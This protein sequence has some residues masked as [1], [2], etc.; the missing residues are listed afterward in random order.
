ME[1]QPGAELIYNR[2]QKHFI[3][4]S[5]DSYI[6]TYAKQGTTWVIAIM[7]RLRQLEDN[8]QFDEDTIKIRLGMEK[9]GAAPWV[10]MHAEIPDYI[11]R[12]EYFENLPKTRFR[13]FKSHS[14]IGLLPRSNEPYFYSK[15]PENVEP[16]NK[17]K[18]VIILRNPL[19]QMVSLWHHFN[20]KYTFKGTFEAFFK[21]Y[22]LTSKQE[23]G[24]WLKYH[25]DLFKA[26]KTSPEDFDYKVLFYEELQQDSGRNAI[27][28]L[29]EF[30][31][32][33]TNLTP[34]RIDQIVDLT[35]FASMSK[36]A[37]TVGF[38]KL[39]PDHGVTEMWKG[40]NEGDASNFSMSH[41][42]RGKV[43]DALNEGYF[44]EDLLKLWDEYVDARI[45]SSQE[46]IEYV[47]LD[48]IRRG[49][50]LKNRN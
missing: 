40:I 10:E 13:L 23:N 27:E 6:L 19:D 44:T 7:E 46:L 1:E 33:K 43:G 29:A 32:L 50:A 24:D 49:G 4:R 2:I 22:C 36:M 26:Y 39:F 8:N 18:H 37:N 9:E 34:E 25:N 16:I 15:R 41:I 21:E 38:G 5:D 30:Y 12:F 3:P 47:G 20:A 11:K 42:R 31:D 35:S 17:L 14:P 48:Y 28:T 45:E